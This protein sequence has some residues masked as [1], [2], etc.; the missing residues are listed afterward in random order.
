MRTSNRTIQVRAIL[1]S[2]V[3]VRLGAVLI[4]ASLILGEGVGEEAT[5]VKGVGAIMKLK[6]GE[7]VGTISVEHY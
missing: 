7:G 5:L 4:G 2:V 3:G 6:L 1:V